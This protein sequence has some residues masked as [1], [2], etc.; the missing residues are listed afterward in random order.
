MSQNFQYQ[1]VDLSKGCS[2]IF[3]P[4]YFDQICDLIPDG[5]LVIDRKGKIVYANLAVESISG[6]SPSELIG[7][8][9]TCLLYT[10][11]SPRD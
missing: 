5:I 11:P 7:K 9:C 3:S 4:A 10:S 6:Y 1:D 8:P 2:A